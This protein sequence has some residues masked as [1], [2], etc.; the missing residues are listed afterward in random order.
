[1]PLLGEARGSR[2]GVGPWREMIPGGI[3]EWQARAQCSSITSRGR[4]GPAE[5]DPALHDREGGTESP[6]DPQARDPAQ[7]TLWWAFD[8]ASSGAGCD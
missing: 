8:W 3:W 1:M 5:S 6:R 2:A 4:V 7:S